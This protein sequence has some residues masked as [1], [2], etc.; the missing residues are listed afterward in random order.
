ML[1]FSKKGLL[2]ALF[3]LAGSYF[4]FAQDIIVTKD[5]KKIKVKVVRVNPDNVRYKDANDPDGATHI[6]LKKDIA[7]ILYEDG[8]VEAFDSGTTQSTQPAQTQ[9]QRPVANNNRQAVAPAPMDRYATAQASTGGDDIRKIR[10]GIKGGLNGAYEYTSDGQTDARFGLH[11]GVLVEAPLSNK[12]D[13]QPELLYSMQ[14]C[15]GKDGDTDKLDYIN[16]PIMF[17][18]YVNQSRSFSIDLG[19][20]F[21]YLIN[22]KTEGSSYIIDWIK[23]ANKFDVAVCLGV[24]YKITP[25]FFLGLRFNYGVTKIIKEISDNRNLVAQLSVGYLF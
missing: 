1:K 23:V 21:G 3:M 17:K 16:L 15:K 8:Q 25:D 4:C 2:M 9:T 20:Q 22:A 13:I 12:V 19:P 24:S 18:I 7:S 5:A 10:F 14:G 11:V 6:M